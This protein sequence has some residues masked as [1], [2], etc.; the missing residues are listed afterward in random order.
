MST[1][2]TA[3]GSASVAAMEVYDEV[4]VSRLFTPWG[5]VLLGE[6]A[7]RPGES[8]LD[9][10][11]GPG[12]VTRMAAHRVGRQG[13]LLGCDLSA[14]MLAIGRAKPGLSDAAP[15]EYVEAPADALPVAS[16]SFDVAVC[17]QGLQFF[18]DRSAALAEVH[19]TLRPGGRVGIA[20]WTAIEDS[21]VFAAMYEALREAT[22]DELAERYRAG[23]WGLPEAHELHDLVTAAGFEGVLV[24]RHTVDVVFEGGPAQF[25]STLAASG[26][27]AEVEALPTEQQAELLQAFDE[28]A[29]P[30]CRDG[31]LRST[32]TSNVA[33]ARR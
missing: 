5:D 32:T 22:G 12:S 24:N 26:I 20:V 21:P 17:Q 8:V 4:F 15:I 33:L 7:L 29:S 19:R 16:E 2:G 10:A 6:L 11:C 27:A 23:P 28:H 9:V 18:P 1:W 25:A 14:A 30:L 3:F 13:R 31:T